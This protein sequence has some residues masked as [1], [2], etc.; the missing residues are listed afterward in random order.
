VNNKI[1]IATNNSVEL[2]TL[3]TQ[4]PD[5][6][7][8]VR[9]LWTSPQ[10][11]SDPLVWR[12]DLPQATKDKLR[13]F[14]VNYGKTDPHEK[15]VMANITGYSGFDASSDAQLVPIRQIALFQQKEKIE[16]DAHL[17]DADKKTQLAALEQQMN[18]L[19]ASA[20]AKQ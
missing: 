16:S 6:Y 4:H 3:K 2:G 15:Q 18:A 7:A 19:E 12:R 17:S 13:N 1:D 5:K 8:Q 20:G 10:I 9:V 11:P 14:F